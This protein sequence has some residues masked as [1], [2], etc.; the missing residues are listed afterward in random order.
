MTR[1][2]ISAKQRTSLKNICL[3]NKID[4]SKFEVHQPFAY[5]LNENNILRGIA[6]CLDAKDLKGIIEIVKIY[7]R[8]LREAKA[9]EKNESSRPVALKKTK[10]IPLTY[11]D[12]ERR[13]VLAVKK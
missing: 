4:E 13:A 10:Q 6:E 2:K 7:N 8:T 9:L 1:K 12:R 5:L 3:D 11:E